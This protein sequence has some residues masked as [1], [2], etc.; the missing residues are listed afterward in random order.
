MFAPV[1]GKK[2]HRT[3]G[4]FQGPFL[5]REPM[6]SKV[7][8]SWWS[9]SPRHEIMPTV[10]LGVRQSLHLRQ[11]PGIGM[12]SYDGDHKL[13]SK[14][15]PQ[16]STC[17]TQLLTF[18]HLSYQTTKVLK[19][20]HFLSTWLWPQPSKNASGDRWQR[21]SSALHSPTCSG[22]CKRLVAGKDHPVPK[23]H[24]RNPHRIH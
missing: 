4:P 7:W 14:M 18:I 22:R 9:P 21:L 13:G 16:C 12:E 11:S 5:L 20:S 2:G 1:H 24:T 6:V 23:K 10:W 19:P 17:V 15:V 3:L 8:L